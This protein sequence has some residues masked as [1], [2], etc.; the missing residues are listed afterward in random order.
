MKNKIHRAY[1]NYAIPMWLSHEINQI[2]INAGE[3]YTNGMVQDSADTKPITYLPTLWKSITSIISARV[4]AHL[5]VSDILSEEQ[6]GCQAGSRGCKERL[7]INSI[8]IGQVT[9]GQSLF[10]VAMSFTPKAFESGAR[11]WRMD[12]LPQYRINPKPIKLLATVIEPHCQ[13]ANI[14]I[15]TPESS[16]TCGEPFSK[17]T[18]YIPFSSVW[19]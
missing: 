4:N 10:L 5:E 17:K 16:S 18:H 19:R 13:S 2:I 11:I 8:V 3:N 15:P 12:V 7:I 6:R 14:R 1:R 9:R